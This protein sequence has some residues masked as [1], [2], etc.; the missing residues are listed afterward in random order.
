MKEGV[1][2]S[3]DK[4]SNF[5][6]RHLSKFIVNANGIFDSFQRSG[7]DDSSVEELIFFSSAN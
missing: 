5:S 1:E 4:I 6:H 7:E 2:S 3:A